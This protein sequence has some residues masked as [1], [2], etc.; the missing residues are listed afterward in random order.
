MSRRTRCVRKLA[1]LPPDAPMKDGWKALRFR[2]I[3]GRWP[4]AAP[5]WR[6]AAPP[7]SRA[8]TS[9]ASRPPSTRG[10]ITDKGSIN[11]RAALQHRDPL[12]KALHDPVL[13][14][15]TKEERNMKG[16]PDSSQAAPRGSARR[17]RASSHAWASRSRRLTSSSCRKRCP[18]LGKPEEFAQLAC[19][20]VTDT[21][22]NR[23]VIR[24][25]GAVQGT[26]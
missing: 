17:R 18:R 23:E 12:V 19:H 9:C 13:H 14:P 22:L 7:G 26:A 16:A 6:S 15:S 3:S 25:G 1:G 21:E 24:L 8:C 11:Q 2:S 10:E 4:T 5:R 20:I